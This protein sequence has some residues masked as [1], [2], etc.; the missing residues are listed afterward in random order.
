MTAPDFSSG[1]NNHSEAIAKPRP[2]STPFPNTLPSTDPKT[3]AHGNGGFRRSLPEGPGCATI[4]L[5]V[6][7][8]LMREQVSGVCG[9]APRREIGGRTDYAPLALSDF[10]GGRR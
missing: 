9:H 7:D 8:G 2:A 6:D 4:A 1:A 10:A 3:A 5:L